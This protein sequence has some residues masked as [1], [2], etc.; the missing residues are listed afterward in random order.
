MVLRRVRSIT[1]GIGR[2]GPWKSRLFWALKWLRAKRVPFGPSEYIKS[3][4]HT[5]VLYL[6]VPTGLGH[7]PT[8]QSY[9]RVGSVSCRIK[10]TAAPFFVSN[11]QI[12][13]SLLDSN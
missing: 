11:L 7:P 6:A 12:N 9:T 5:R 2:G 1:S 8:L 10:L 4:P 3:A 13:I